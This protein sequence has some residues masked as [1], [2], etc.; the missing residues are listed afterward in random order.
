MKRAAQCWLVSASANFAIAIWRLKREYA[1]PPGEGDSDGKRR[2]EKKKAALLSAIRYD[3]S[4]TSLTN[5]HCCY[6]FFSFRKHVYRDIVNH[7][8][9]QIPAPGI[10]VRTFDH[11]LSVESAI[12]FA[13]PFSDFIMS[14]LTCSLIR[15]IHKISMFMNLFLVQV[16]EKLDHVL[17]T[18]TGTSYFRPRNILDYFPPLCRCCRRCF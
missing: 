16:V 18:P 17:L 4:L 6:H 7:H 2:R 13:S 9:S 12:S 15:R 5:A 3:S 8:S 1:A 14:L 11:H 10:F